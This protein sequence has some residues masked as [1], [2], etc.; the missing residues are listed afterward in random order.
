MVIIDMTKQKIILK[1]SVTIIFLLVASVSS[2]ASINVDRDSKKNNNYNQILIND[3]IL[4][5]SDSHNITGLPGNE[6]HPALAMDLNGNLFGAY[7]YD[8]DGKIKWVYSDDNGL[9]WKVI[10]SSDGLEKY[11]SVD[12]WGSNSRFFATFVTPQSKGNGGDIY[13]IEYNPSEQLFPSIWDFS[14]NGT[15]NMTDVDIACDNSQKTEEFGVMSIV[16]STTYEGGP[17]KNGPFLF[18]ID[19]DNTIKGILNW[20]EH[21]SNCFHTRADIDPVSHMAYGVYDRLN[22]SKW[23][24]LLRVLDFNNT[25]SGYNETFEIKETGDLACPSVASYDDNLVI[26]AETNERGGNIDIVCKYSDSASNNGVFGKSFVAQTDDFE[27]YPEI[28]WVYGKTF[29]C[30]FI[31]N[32]YI[33]RSITNDGGA[34]WD[35]PVQIS[36]NN[37]YVVDAYKSVDM[38]E[39]GLKCMWEDSRS[40]DIDVYLGEV[41][42]P[43]TSTITGYVNDTKGNKLKD[44][45]IIVKNKNWSWWQTSTI[46]NETGGYTINVIPGLINITAEKRGYGS[47]SS[48]F[49]VADSSTNWWNTTLK[50]LPAYLKIGPINGGLGVSATIKNVGQRDIKNISWSIE[51]KGKRHIWGKNPVT[52]H[53][54]S[55][56]GEFSTTIGSKL[57][58]G[59]G[60]VNVTITVSADDVPTVTRSSNGFLLGFWII[61]F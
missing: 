15:Y 19:P 39:H 38:S 61:I 26:V 47:N 32:N 11:P 46:T 1:I 42:N 44:A 45:T 35:N 41:V 58:V 8:T 48:E 55:L 10:S 7:E 20:D 34:T 17:V 6:T 53:I 57:L 40:S 52:G 60:R 31:K 29:V 3:E 9:T 13:L 25:E 22:G 30:T 49:T 54:S 59:F 12:Y 24:L 43:E 56:E 4:T 28:E 33:F 2:V 16:M 21:Y 36:D 23:Q 37:S 50:E 5:L 27:S 51:V 14:K 18:Y